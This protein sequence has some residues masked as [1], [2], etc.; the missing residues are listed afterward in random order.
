[1]G[2]AAHSAFGLPDAAALGLPDEVGEGG[3]LAR[4]AANVGCIACKK[5]A[6]AGIGEALVQQSCHGAARG[7]IGDQA[8]VAR[9]CLCERQDVWAWCGHHGGQKGLK[10]A[11]GPTGKG[12]ELSGG[13][14]AESLR[15]LAQVPSVIVKKIKRGA[16]GPEMP[17]QKRCADQAY[18][19]GHL[20]ACLGENLLKDMRHG[21]DSWAR[22]HR[23]GR[24]WQCANLAACVG[25]ALKDHNARAR[26]CQTRGGCQTADARTDHDAV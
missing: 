21:Q 13:L 25:M 16:V 8:R 1:M 6:Q 17:G 20:R 7:Q 4:T 9:K 18:V 19:I 10:K 5:R 15:D 14:W 22:I 24:A 23:T 3:H 26:T 2:Q 12:L 11:G